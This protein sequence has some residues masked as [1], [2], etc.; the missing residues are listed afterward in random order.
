MHPDQFPVGRDRLILRGIPEH[1]IA[2]ALAI[3]L[4][5]RLHLG[6]ISLGQIK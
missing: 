2:Q 5:D 4:I 3:T 6:G 1:E